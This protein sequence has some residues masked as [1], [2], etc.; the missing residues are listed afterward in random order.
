M[1]KIFLITLLLLSNK[2]THAQTQ[3]DTIGLLQ[4]AIL[5]NKSNF[6]GKPFSTLVNALPASLP[7]KHYSP[8]WFGGPKNRQTSFGFIDVENVHRSPK[9][10]IYIYIGKIRK[11]GTVKHHSGANYQQGNGV[12]MTSIITRT[13]SSRI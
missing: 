6:I 9:N 12:R 5:N 3:V 11:V 10:I 2:A 7:I 4:Q 1:K 13:G 8:E